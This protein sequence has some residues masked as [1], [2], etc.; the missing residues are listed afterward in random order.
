MG[1]KYVPKANGPNAAVRM[2]MFD[3][4]RFTAEAIN[5]YHRGAKEFLVKAW[6]EEVLERFHKRGIDRVLRRPMRCP[7]IGEGKCVQRPKQRWL[8]AMRVV[9]LLRNVAKNTAAGLDLV[10]RRDG[11][12]LKSPVEP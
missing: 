3:V 6:G 1:D 9:R 11:V 10:Q 8:D 5:G 12:P 7:F 2:F 4:K